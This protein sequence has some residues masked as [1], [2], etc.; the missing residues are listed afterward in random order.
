MIVVKII[1][2]LWRILTRSIHLVMKPIL[3]PLALMKGGLI[4]RWKQPVYIYLANEYTKS[5]HTISC[6]TSL[7]TSESWV[8]SLVAQLQFQV[9]EA[10]LHQPPVY[11]WKWQIC[12]KKFLIDIENLEHKF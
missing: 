6:S 7:D 5:G 9:I 3:S 4:C 2:L 8:E 1:L 11:D 12:Q 10:A